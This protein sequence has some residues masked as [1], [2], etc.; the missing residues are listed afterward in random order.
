MED[1]QYYLAIVIVIVVG[2]F[3]IKRITSCLWNIVVGLIVLA[4]L[5]WALTELGVI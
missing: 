1:L 5:A 3:A 4:V 2:F